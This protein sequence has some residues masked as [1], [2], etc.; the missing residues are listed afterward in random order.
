MLVQTKRNK[1][2]AMKLM[3]TLLKKY[4]FV[5]DKLV[6]DDRGP[7]GP[8]SMIWGF[9]TA[10]S[11]VDGATTEPRTRINRPDD[12]NAR[13]RASSPGSKDFSQLTQPHTTLSMSN[14][15]SFRQG[16]T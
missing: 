3:R 5:P 2:A 9:R 15:I 10:T 8:Q 11:A 13:C 16:P 4:G 14:A 6:T 12:E 7:I 1:R